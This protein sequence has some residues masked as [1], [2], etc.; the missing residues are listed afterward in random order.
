MLHLVGPQAAGGR[1][2]PG[3]RARPRSAGRRRSTTRAP[4]K[5]RRRLPRRPPRGA[6]CGALRLRRRPKPRLRREAGRRSRRQGRQEVTGRPGPTATTGR[7]RGRPGLFRA[8]RIHG[9][10][11]ALRS[12]SV[13]AIPGP[14]TG[15]RATT[16]ASGSS[17]RLRARMAR[18]SARTR[19]TRARS[20]ACTLEGREVVLLKPKTYMNRSGPRSARCCDYFKAPVGEMLVA[21]D[22]LDL[23]PGVA[24]LQARRRPRRPQR[25]ARHHHALRRRLLAPAPRHRSSRRQVAGD[26]L[27][28][29]ARGAGG[30]G[31][32]RAEHRRGA[33]CADRVRRA[34]APR[35][36]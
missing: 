8:A 28:A 27:R 22:E 21:H 26:R 4:R 16:R 34:T 31:G 17:T 3:A 13:S 5:P 18:S 29:A 30:R 25:P 2:D 1:R 24:R 12:S 19:A 6:G 35:R 32:D 10:H 7:P 23:P 15:S 9:G 14:S 33:R 11:T 20:A 36:P